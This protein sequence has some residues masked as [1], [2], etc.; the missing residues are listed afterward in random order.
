VACIKLCCWRDGWPG[1]G[2]LVLTETGVKGREEFW[3]GVGHKHMLCFLKVAAGTEKGR[4]GESN[5][6][7]P[8]SF[9]AWMSLHLSLHTCKFPPKLVFLCLI[10][11]GQGTTL[12]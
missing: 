1:Q 3:H 2:P 12:E 11:C 9:L 8:E 7:C 6:G 10:F 4:E 5:G